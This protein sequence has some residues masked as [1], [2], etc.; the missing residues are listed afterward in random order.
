[1]HKL[2]GHLGYEL[3]ERPP[4]AAART[5][6]QTLHDFL[7]RSSALV[8]EIVLTSVVLLLVHLTIYHVTCLAHEQCQ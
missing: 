2:T 1:M 3:N 6:E 8:Q 5:R 7:S 4:V